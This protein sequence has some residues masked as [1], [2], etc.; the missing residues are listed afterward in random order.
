MT[1]RDI[2]AALQAQVAAALEERRT[3][4]IVGGN[5]KSFLGNAAAGDRLDVSPHRGVISYEPTELVITARSGT[6]LASIEALL[7]E[8][9]QMLAFEP[10]HY[11][12]TATLGGTIAANLSGP[13]RAYAGAARD[14]VLGTRL[15]NGRA[16]D[17]HFGGEVMK[18]VAGYDVSRLMAG[19]LGTLGVLLE[20]SLKVLP[21][22]EAEVTLVQSVDVH[23]A[24]KLMHDWGVQPLPISATCFYGE[25]LAVRLCGSEGGVRAARKKIGGDELPHA[26]EFWQQIR[27]QRKSVFNSDQSLWRLSLASD[28]APLDMGKTVY[29][30]GGALRW[31]QSDAPV[32]D[33]QQAACAAGG[34]A[35]LYR[36]R[37]YAESTP[38]FQ[39]LAA[40]LFKVHQQL[41]HAFD[42]QGIFNPGRLYPAL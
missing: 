27:E 10:P 18:N 35:T 6:P 4:N 39:P 25:R 21:L 28:S 41:K 9:G 16:E 38:A 36:N 3:L 15:L 37:S 22:P 2:S 17:L 33:I 12:D 14:Y 11:G 29:E 8:H 42:P 32:A 23:T 24:L 26:A 20:V 40:G 7:A 5:S 30:W 1:D 31:L 19:A 13:R 34:H